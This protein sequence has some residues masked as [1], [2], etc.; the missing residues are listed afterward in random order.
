MSQVNDRFYTQVREA[1]KHYD[2]L[3]RIANLPLAGLAL[4]TALLQDIKHPT[5]H[6]GRGKAL[7]QAIRVCLEELKSVFAESTDHT[8]LCLHCYIFKTD[9]NYPGNKDGISNVA[10]YLSSNYLIHKKA[11][12]YEYL[13]PGLKHLSYHLQAYFAHDELVPWTPEFV[14]REEELARCH[15][16]LTH[17]RF[18]VLE[19]GR[20]IGKTALAA[21]LTHR[22]AVES[23]QPICWLTIRAN[24][25]DNLRA[26]IYVWAKFLARQGDIRLRELIRSTSDELEFTHDVLPILKT[27][28]AA[29]NPLLCLDNVGLIDNIAHWFWSLLGELYRAAQVSL[30]LTSRRALP[31]PGLEKA[32]VLEGLAP[33]ETRAL[34]AQQH[35]PLSQPQI[36]IL[37]AQTNGNP[38]L[39]KMF[40]AYAQ[41]SKPHYGT[42]VEQFLQTG[43]SVQLFTTE[44]LT[45]LT[46]SELGAALLLSLPRLPVDSMLLLEPPTELSLQPLGITPHDFEV[47][48]QRGLIE[49]ALSG[50]WQLA[51]PVR[52]YLRQTKTDDTI[53]HIEPPALHQWFEHL[54][55]LQDEPVEAAYHAVHGKN[56]LQAISLLRSQQHELL[57]QGKAPAM[58]AILNAIA[59]DEL[60][61][62]DSP[63]ATT[64]VRQD[65]RE[66]KAGVLHI[67]GEYDEAAKEVHAIEAQDAAVKAR[68]S[69][70]LGRL[71][72]RRGHVTPAITYYNE[73]LRWSQVKQLSLEAWLHRELAWTTME[74]GDLEQAWAEAQRARIALE[75]TQAK[76]AERRKDDKRALDHLKEAKTM[77][78]QAG[79]IL[80]LAQATN[81]L[82]AF[83]KHRSNLAAAIAEFQ[84]VLQLSTEIGVLVGQA[85][86][87]LHL[88]MCHEELE[89]YSQAIEYELAALEIFTKLG[90][91]KG[92][93]L[94]HANLAEAYLHSAQPDLAQEHAE[95]ATQ[96]IAAPL[97]DRA[98]AQ[99]IYAEVLSAQGNTAT[100]REVAKNAL[101]LLCISDSADAAP[102]YADVQEAEWV[103]ET[104]IKIYER[105]GEI[106]EAR[107]CAAE[108]QRLRE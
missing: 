37:T 99:R 64:I 85:S 4:R 98:E 74:E 44:T 76:I 82:G 39:L 41:N 19:G 7:Q 58:Y 86:G 21:Q 51:P 46:D 89:E 95:Q 62:P 47:L 29:V 102:K 17:R 45:T 12:H 56:P 96:I 83:Y 57:G 106:A 68:L 22:I 6:E 88:G 50:L 49:T 10:D 63:T 36:E 33:P 69:M 13:V 71:A 20:G 38:R 87:L 32:I 24:V 43:A 101:A 15:D 67:L 5:D 1:C 3:A 93:A 78:W 94:A 16:Q 75:F 40:V 59:E 60:C 105:R 9:P 42:A 55:S 35:L 108:I 72:K 48:Q 61:V 80:L 54:Y 91:A 26:I 34:L 84:K 53:P 97:P 14:G 31:V 77:A 2:N 30:L 23:K 90:D 8:Y 18:A 65:W 92:H 100:A 27:A 104:L 107:K 52:D 66:L 103:L 81:N 28:L 70:L 11:Y 73:A 25:N 79:E